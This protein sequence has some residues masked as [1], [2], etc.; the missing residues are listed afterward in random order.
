MN[1]IL[2]VEG[3]V[4]IAEKTDIQIKLPRKFHCVLH[5]DDYTPM[6]FVVELLINIF[7][8]EVERAAAIML[9]IHHSNRGIAGTYSKEV[10]EQRAT[11][12]EKLAELAEY[13][14]RCSIEPVENGDD[15]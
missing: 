12:A 8:H 4:A 15:D 10:A 3:D 5:N 13:P 1:S 2:D 6:D 11:D 14:L 7:N 9:E